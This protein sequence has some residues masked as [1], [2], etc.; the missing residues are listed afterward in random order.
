MH[1]R[2]ARRG[3]PSS[4]HGVHL[5]QHDR[6]APASNRATP[7]ASVL[8]MINGI[9]NI[10]L[11][12]V[13]LLTLS[14]EDRLGPIPALLL[15]VGIPASFGVWELAR[16]RKI[17]ASAIMGVVSVLLT[18]V[19]GVF[20]LPTSLFPIKEALIPVGFAIILLVSNRMAFPVVKLLFDMVQR[21]DRVERLVR[22]RGMQAAY[23]AHIERSG[24]IW[25]GIMF[26]SGVMK[27]ILSSIVVNAPAGTDQFNTQLAFYELVQIPTSMMVTMVL[28]LS[29][30]FFIARGTGAMIDLGPSEVLRGGE[31][32]ARVGQRFAPVLARFQRSA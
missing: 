8:A 2:A 25:A 15:A 18:G 10:L 13:I 20:E 6:L 9:V 14:D 21:K 19:I 1:K 26:L 30:I 32:M 31:K 24:T 4:L 16:T 12:V 3:R 22:E 5:C 23:R 17:N 27:F 11:P 7:G 29:L 28:I